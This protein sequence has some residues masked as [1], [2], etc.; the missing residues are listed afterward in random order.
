MYLKPFLSLCAAVLVASGA[1]AQIVAEFDTSLGKFSAQ[2][3]HE[4][5][6]RTVASFVGLAEGSRPWLDPE[7]GSIQLG[8]P[9]YDGISFHRVIDGF[10][11]QTGSRNGLG[12]DGPGYRFLDEFDPTLRHDAAYVLSMA[13]SGPNTNGSQFFVT[14]DPTT[15]LDDMHSVFGQIISGQDVVAAIGKTPVDDSDRPT[16]PVVVNSV[17]ITRT[18]ESASAF[19]V[20]A[21]GL[22][23]IH[24][25]TDVE[26]LDRDGGGRELAFDIV[27]NSQVGLHTS[28]DLLTWE[29]RDIPFFHDNVPT[30]NLDVSAATEGMNEFYF[31]TTDVRYTDAFVPVSIANSTLE[32]VL[33]WDDAPNQTLNFNITE[34]DGDP[35]GDYIL[36]G[37]ATGD[38]TSIAITA[39][40]PYWIAMNATFSDLNPAQIIF[41]FDS[42]GRGRHTGVLRQLFF[43]FTETFINGTFTFTQR[44]AEPKPVPGE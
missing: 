37:E 34:P 1:S 32:L 6:P 26:I 39:R 36:D 14:L 29:P 7:D 12:T 28:A 11:I 16:T 13:N 40:G 4:K 44:E 20:N 19:D 2:L 35:S 17:K 24:A 5:A 18:G 3:E 33:L 27:P 8:N 31:R 43:P 30:V 38:I 15:H 41:S 21:H 10:V 42:E 23:T 25:I 9:F 22:P